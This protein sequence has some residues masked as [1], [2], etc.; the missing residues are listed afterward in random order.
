MKYQEIDGYRTKI[1]FEYFIMLEQKDNDDMA[2]AA[3]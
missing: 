3:Y 2:G 1:K